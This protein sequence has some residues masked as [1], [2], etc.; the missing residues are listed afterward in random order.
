MSLNS[1][2]VI[3]SGFFLIMNIVLFCTDK[4]LSGNSVKI[5]YNEAEPAIYTDTQTY[6][7]TNKSF[8]LTLPRNIDRG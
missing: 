1:V 7:H 8:F 6:T 5:Q 2:S 4:T 3:N